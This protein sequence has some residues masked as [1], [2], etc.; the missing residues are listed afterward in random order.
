VFKVV[1]VS[2]IYFAVFK[3]L[4]EGSACESVH[5]VSVGDNKGW[6]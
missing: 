1:V 2:E 3:P 5:I 4:E 6:Q